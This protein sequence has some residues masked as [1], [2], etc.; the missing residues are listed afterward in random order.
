MEKDILEIFYNEIIPESSFG[1]VEAFLPLIL[2]LT[3]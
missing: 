3:H 2:D 1:K